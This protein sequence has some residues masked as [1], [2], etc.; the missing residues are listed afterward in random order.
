MEVPPSLPQN[1]EGLLVDLVGD[2][3][4]ENLF[5]VVIEEYLLPA[6][7]SQMKGWLLTLHPLKGYLGY[8]QKSQKQVL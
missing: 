7:T 6:L 1:K 4:K 3:Q 5:S 8:L 2:I